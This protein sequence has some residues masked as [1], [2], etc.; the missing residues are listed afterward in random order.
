VCV[1]GDVWAAYKHWAS[2]DIWCFYPT[3]ATVVALN[4]APYWLVILA[5]SLFT[6]IA[7][8]FCVAV[9]CPSAVRVAFFRKG[10]YL[11]IALYSRYRWFVQYDVLRTSSQNS[12]LIQA[13]HGSSIDSGF[14]V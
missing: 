3:A 8:H 10:V 13:S 12:I 9:T 11:V 4:G 2:N 6:N 7:L 14:G 5:D 1:V